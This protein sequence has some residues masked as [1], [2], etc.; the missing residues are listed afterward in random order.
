MSHNQCCRIFIPSL[1]QV[2]CNLMQPLR[3]R[4]TRT[5]VCPTG[6]SF[7]ANLREI[8]FR[9]PHSNPK[10]VTLGDYDR[11]RFGSGALKNG[12]RFTK[13]QVSRKCL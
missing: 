8:N 3:I 4:V 13:S 6:H 9:A 10:C 7:R 11:G 5:V 12:G 2:P 1:T